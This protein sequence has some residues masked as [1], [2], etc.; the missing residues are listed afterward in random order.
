MPGPTSTRRLRRW[1]LAV[2]DELVIDE[3][4]AVPGHDEMAP[5]AVGMIY[6]FLA[7][8]TSTG[9][10]ISRE[11]DQLGES[12]EHVADTFAVMA[13]A[14]LMEACGGQVNARALADRWARKIATRQ[15]RVVQARKDK[16]SLSRSDSAR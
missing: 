13:A 16:A 4:T 11:V 5:M 15:A 7:G 9:I 1:G 2:A 10:M 6:A 14:M 12:H 3:F 8:D